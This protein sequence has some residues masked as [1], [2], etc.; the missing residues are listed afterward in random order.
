MRASGRRAGA[1][2][3]AIASANRHIFSAAIAAQGAGSLER[4]AA[5]VKH[6]Q[7]EAMASTSSHKQG[8]GGKY[9]LQIMPRRGPRRGYNR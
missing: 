8:S 3:L 1:L 2:R 4:R 6:Q 9:G 7:I 5:A